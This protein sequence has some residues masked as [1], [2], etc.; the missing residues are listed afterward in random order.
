L[1][2]NSAPTGSSQIGRKP[3]IILVG[4]GHVFDMRGAVKGVVHSM[5]PGT[6]ALELDQ[7]R[8]AA[9]LTEER[10][11]GKGLPLIYR[12]LAKLQKNIAEQY[13]SEAGSEMIAAAE[14]ANEIGAGIEL[15][16]MDAL[17]VFRR[18]T[19]AMSIKEKLLMVFGI[20]VSLV[21]GKS[22]VEK[23]MEMYKSD[24][25]GFMAEV[26]RTYPS[27]ARVLIDER[28]EHMAG[29]LRGISS[30][31][32]VTLAVVGDAHI[33]GLSGRLSEFADVEVLRL[34]DLQNRPQGGENANAQMTVSFVVHGPE[35]K[36]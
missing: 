34:D 28:N 21:A 1:N 4:V 12:L 31:S 7:G 26:K 3:T 20:F 6:V 13:G 33:Q 23:E 22:A 29:R 30:R 24:E 8:F 9:L 19:G 25:E 5:R 10:G 27:I 36:P 16:D 32:D 14:A 11:N 35:D 2:Q 15:I 17:T 18:M